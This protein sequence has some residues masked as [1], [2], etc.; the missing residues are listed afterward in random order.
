[1]NVQTLLLTGLLFSLASAQAQQSTTEAKKESTKEVSTESKATDEQTAEVV[2]SSMKNPDLKPYRIMSAGMDAYDENRHLAPQAPILFKLIPRDKSKLQD[3]NWDNVK[4]RLA[5]DDASIPIPLIKE[6]SFQLPR[7]KKAYEDNAELLLNQ[8][9]SSY[10]FRPDIRTPGIADN[11]LRRGDIR[12]ECEMTV[13]MAKKEMGFIL[14][15]LIS[16]ILLKT[17]WCE[18][19]RFVI[20]YYSTKEWA[21]S[22]KTV[23]GDQSTS[24]KFRGK[25]FYPNFWDKT[26]SPDTLYEFEL[27]PSAS[28]ER[29]QEVLDQQKF[30]VRT[31]SDK[32]LKKF[33]F[34]RNGNV[35]QLDMPLA[36]G[37]FNFQLEADE[38]VLAFASAQDNGKLVLE[39][40]NELKLSESKNSI[41][42]EQAGVY[43]LSLDFT[44]IDQPKLQIQSLDTTA[45]L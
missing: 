26:I 16:T 28:L 11:V 10:S 24:G 6:G 41:K 14:K 40:P 17:D 3:T 30:I 13:D 38:G 2:I 25:T 44:K 27:W 5:S 33:E 43:R 15:S 31:G 20:F 32:T 35:Y 9:K 34:I 7:D 12:L 23:I 29:K 18:T 8:K 4:L 19:K 37:V 36:L 45:N 21:I 1:M 22:M 39:K 42:I